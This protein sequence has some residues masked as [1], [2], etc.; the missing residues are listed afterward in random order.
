MGSDLNQE[1]ESLVIESYSPNNKWISVFKDNG[2]TGYMYLWSSNENGE[3]DKIVDHLW[4]YNQI[5]PP[6]EKCKKVFIIWSDDSNRT[7]LIVDGECWGMFDFSS[8]RKLNAPRNKNTIISVERQVWDNG[9]REN[10]GEPIKLD[11][12]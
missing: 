10:E 8:K 1:K 7:G 2:E 6:I 9:I 11:N 5:N 4:N 3:L 12:V